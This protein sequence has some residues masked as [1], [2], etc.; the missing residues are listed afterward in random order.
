MIIFFFFIHLG[1]AVLGFPG[2]A[3]VKNPSAN[4]GDVGAILGSED[5]LEEEMA[6]HSSIFP[7]KSHGHAA[8]RACPWGR[9]ESDMTEHT[10]THT[11]TV[12]L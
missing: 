11:H 3:V 6:T 8:W 1:I 5:S 9:K 12:A 2:D 4:A 7:G 10:H